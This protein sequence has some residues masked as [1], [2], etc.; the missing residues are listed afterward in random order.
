M[1]SAGVCG[2]PVSGQRTDER[3]SRKT[4]EQL[5][6]GNGRR[7]YVGHRKIDPI[8]FKK[9]NSGLGGNL[10]TGHTWR[11]FILIEP[12]AVDMARKGCDESA[13]QAGMM[14]RRRSP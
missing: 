13:A 9:R 7:L 2:V 10:K 4:T 12:Q 1:Q 8:M 14:G 5:R 11:E 3:E 6:G